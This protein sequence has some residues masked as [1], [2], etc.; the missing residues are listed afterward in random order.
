M[1]IL[2]QAVEAAQSADPRSSIESGLMLMV[3]GMLVV[4]GALV[5]IGELTAVLARLMRERPAMAEVAPVPTREGEGFPVP[6]PGIEEMDSRTLAVI[7]AAAATVVGLGVPVRV[8]RVTRVFHTESGS[9]A[10]TEA[11]R[12]GLQGSHNVRR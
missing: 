1:L 8:R 6:P 2:A 4:F 11:G 5:V 9:S 3:V 12:I 10:W 7:A